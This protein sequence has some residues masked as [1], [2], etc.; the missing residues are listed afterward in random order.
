[1]WKGKTNRKRSERRLQ[2]LRDSVLSSLPRGA[3]PPS[4]LEA[5]RE[6]EQGEDSS[7]NAVQ[8]HAVP[9]LMGD[10]DGGSNSL[11]HPPPPEVDDDHEPGHAPQHVRG[12]ASGFNIGD[13]DWDEDNEWRVH[14]EDPLPDPLPVAVRDPLASVDDD[15]RA[16][17]ID[18]APD[19]GGRVPQSDGDIAMYLAS[20]QA[21]REV[22]IAVMSDIIAYMNENRELFV[23][24]L[25]NNTLKNFRMMRHQALQSVPKVWMDVVGT[26]A[27]GQ[28]V[29][30]N[31]IESFP[32]KEFAAN[33]LQRHVV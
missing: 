16:V 31:H 7:Q 2:R 27:N 8:P 24:A 33:V 14:D 25:T 19:V 15:D 21:R 29:V 22:P 32:R 4:A 20:M 26:D 23:E 18:L 28:R 12:Q 17:A 30:K 11:H 1:M 6:L 5:C 13:A 10:G 9:P 3:V